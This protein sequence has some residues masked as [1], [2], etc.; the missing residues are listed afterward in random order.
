MR[1]FIKHYWHFKRNFNPEVWHDI[2]P[3]SYYELIWVKSGVLYID[4]QEAPK[5]F[6]SGYNERKITLS[7]EGRVEIYGTRFFAWGLVPFIDIE[8]VRNKKFTS[9]EKVLGE[10]GFRVLMSLLTNANGGFYETMNDFFASKILENQ[11]SSRVDGLPEIYLQSKGSLKVREMA[12][13]YSLSSRQ[14]ERFIRRATG[15]TPR[16]LSARI[17]FE[18][19]RKALVNNEHKTLSEL[20]TEYGYT[21]QSHLNKE[22]RKFTSL[23]PFQ[24]KSEFDTLNAHLRSSRGWKWD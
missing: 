20:A 21:D 4:G 17:R 14:L 18:N 12:K 15:S 10:D 3:D 11:S 2:Y 9:A 24:Y 5:L 6:F 22:F 19:V 8:V 13:H 7:G 1:P 23:T 16:E